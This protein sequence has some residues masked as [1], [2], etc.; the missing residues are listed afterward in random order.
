MACRFA[1][2]AAIAFAI[3]VATLAPHAGAERTPRAGS[4]E[5]VRA[6]AETALLVTGT[7]DVDAPGNVVGF[8]IDQPDK[9]P[10]GVIK[11]ANE[12]IPAWTFE[13]TTLPDG[14]RATRMRMSML[15]VAREVSKG[16]F[17]VS[18]RHPSF[19]AMDARRSIKVKS[20][21]RWFEYPPAALDYGVTGTVFLVV[22]FDRSG[23]IVD[24]VVE[25]VNLGV[26]DTEGR[27]AMW[28]DMLGK[29][30]LRRVRHVQVEI[31]DGL[32]AAGEQTLVARL[33]VKFT[34]NT[35]GDVPYGKWVAY[36]PGPRA[37]VPWPDAQGLTASAPD[38]L[39]PD[40]LQTNDARTRR[41]RDAPSR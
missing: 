28:R 7:I 24:A 40:M 23:K 34:I 27:M 37:A 17:E 26:V 8:T 38:A 14:V 29:S 11:M 3:S 1:R 22:R 9:L 13:P 16:Q 33:P 30:V 12:N 31:Q 6:T 5:A 21:S 4:I 20:G 39:L 35:R 10:A 32:F 18:L 25:Q 15:F 36:V 2:A 41:M 19:W